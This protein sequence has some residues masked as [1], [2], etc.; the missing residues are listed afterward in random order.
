MVH[1]QLRLTHS[2]CKKSSALQELE[3][4]H[5]RKSLQQ[6]Q[7]RQTSAAPHHIAYGQA[8]HVLGM[9]MLPPGFACMTSRPNPLASLSGLPHARG[10][11]THAQPTDALWGACLPRTSA[12]AINLVVKRAKPSLSPL[13]QLNHLVHVVDVFGPTIPDRAAFCVVL[14]TCA[15]RGLRNL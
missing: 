6:V 10:H 12:T 9:R 14:L 3:T 1:S 2:R 11:R 15:E 5:H 8:Q 4:L 7:K 13:T